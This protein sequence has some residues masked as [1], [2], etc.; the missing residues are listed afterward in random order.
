MR[1]AY[2]DVCGSEALDTSFVESSPVLPVRPLSLCPLGR[3]GG[4]SLCRVF[5]SAS[6]GPVGALSGLVLGPVV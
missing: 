6:C 5:E 2:F 4:Q 3:R 1:V